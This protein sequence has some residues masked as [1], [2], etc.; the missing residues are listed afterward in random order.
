MWTSRWC[1]SRAFTLIELLVVIAII[2]TLASLLLPAL[3]AAKG[4][5]GM[6][7]CKSNL[8]QIGLGLALYVTDE[9]KYPHEF[10]DPPSGVHGKWWF[11]SI[12]PHVG[13]TWTNE[14]Y[15]C[16]ANK[17]GHVFD[18]NMMVDGIYAQGS[19]GYNA[20]GTERLNGMDLGVN[21]GLGKFSTLR[22]S[23]PRPPSVTESAVMV[24]SDMV[25]LAEGIIATGDIHPSTNAGIANPYPASSRSGWHKV[26]ENVLFC[27]GHLEQL[28]RGQILYVPAM[29]ARWN[30]DN[31][32]H[33]EVW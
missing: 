29:G 31:Q 33:P 12:E 4:R 16:T 18:D 10:L 22:Y 25:A 27:D 11:Q 14:L 28:K 21:L 2:A 1:R 15:R 19:Y 26:G 8:R 30:N 7:R 6:A 17:Y 20:R 9:S 23:G 13:A 5:A 32:P 3:T 24:P